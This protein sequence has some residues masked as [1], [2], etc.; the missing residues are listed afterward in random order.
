MKTKAIAKCLE[1]AKHFRQLAD[2]ETNHLQ[3]TALSVMLPD[4]A[5]ARALY[6]EDRAAELLAAGLAQNVSKKAKNYKKDL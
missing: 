3:A 1:K 4:K 6:W 2:P 5:L